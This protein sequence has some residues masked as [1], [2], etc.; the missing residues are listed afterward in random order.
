[1]LVNSEQDLVDTGKLIADEHIFLI[2]GFSRLSIGQ[3]DK[4]DGGV[5]R[6]GHVHLF[7]GL[8]DADLQD[9]VHA[10]G[11]AGIAADVL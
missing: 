3:P 6:K 11:L 1:M 5:D 7:I 2:S 10:R 4:R 8:D 9:S